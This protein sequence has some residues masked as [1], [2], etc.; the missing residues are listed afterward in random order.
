M[1]FK[2]THALLALTLA[3][4]LPL[5]GCAANP[6]VP[7]VGTTVDSKF[8]QDFSPTLKKGMKW[9]YTEKLV[10]DST[11]HT[12]EFT[13]E[14]T[15]VTNGVATIKTTGTSAMMPGV[16]VNE[17]ATSSLTI[18]VKDSSTT[19]GASFKSE[20]SV[21]VTVPYK[22]FKGAAKLTLSTNSDLMKAT[23]WIAPGVGLVKTELVSSASGDASTY[24]MELKDFV[25]P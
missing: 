16:Q 17:T 3:L 6:A 22:E 18:D 2:P 13:E 1:S 4:G 21:D 14:V 5:V 25:Q 19:E 12:G 7:T 23:Y 10:A 24:T 8:W 15:D 20:G 9:V 11:T